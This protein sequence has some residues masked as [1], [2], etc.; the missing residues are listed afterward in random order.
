MNTPTEL[1]AIHIQGPDDLYA[2]PCKEAAES[3]AAIL[4]DEFKARKIERG[5]NYP[6]I[7][8]AVVPWTG[9][10]EAHADSMKEHLRG[11]A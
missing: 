1:W 7:T 6:S 8:V 11:Q 5:E 10:A 4:N 2:M 9:S 3:H